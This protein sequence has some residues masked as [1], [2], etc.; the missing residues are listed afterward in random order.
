MQHDGL[1]QKHVSGKEEINYSIDYDVTKKL[2]NEKC[3]GFA[4]DSEQQGDL[5]NTERYEE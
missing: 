5:I 4:F 1:W 2:E 3:L